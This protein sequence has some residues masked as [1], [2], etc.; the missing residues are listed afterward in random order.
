MKMLTTQLDMKART[1]VGRTPRIG[2]NHNI[3]YRGRIYHVQTE[4]SGP[5]K[6]HIFTHVFSGGTILSSKKV[7]YG[8]DTHSEDLAG[9]VVRL[10][11]K[12]HKAMLSLL[13][14]GALDERIDKYFGELETRSNGNSSHKRS[15]SAPPAELPPVQLS[16]KKLSALERVQTL[17]ET[18]N[19]A[20]VINSL[21]KLNSEVTGILGAAL[22]D[23]ESG[24][25]LGT[26]GNGINLDVAAAGNTEVVRAKM[27]VMD[28]LGIEGNIEDILITLEK[29][30]HI[31]RPV[32]KTLFLYLA[33]DRKRGNLAMARHTLASVG[34]D[35][36]LS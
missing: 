4:D 30:Y 13:C 19:M 21:N 2:F 1:T 27:R 35:V 9:R 23:H 31:I 26:V 25:C 10:M 29:Q 24:M 36:T 11:Q 22:V 6:G 20:N 14:G 3:A 32:N 33:I 8:P 28:Q 12:S 34:A 7:K 18:I 5:S 16:P 15:T 17:K